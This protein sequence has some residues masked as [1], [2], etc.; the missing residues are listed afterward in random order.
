MKMVQP[1]L[2]VF[3]ERCLSLIVFS[4]LSA[5]RS[6]VV[7]KVELNGFNFNECAEIYYRNSGINITNGKQLCAS[8]EWG[9]DSCN[10]DAGNLIELNGIRNLF[11]FIIVILVN[12]QSQE[13]RW[14][15]KSRSMNQQATI[16]STH[17]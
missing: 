6:E 1:D 8:G 9:K 14:W 5:T 12:V 3:W 7:L 17:T 11:V 10:G 15:L 16:Q 13:V 4:I 2:G